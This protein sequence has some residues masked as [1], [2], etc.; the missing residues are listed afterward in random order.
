[1]LPI[2]IKQ[3]D[4]SSLSIEWNDDTKSE[5]SLIKLR[6]ACPCAICASELESFSH[7]YKVYRGNEVEIADI[8]MVG[9]HAISI[10][11]KDGHRTGMYEFQYLKDLV[12]KE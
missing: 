11:W 12:E 6:K 9:N 3:T 4:N 10:A 5:I 1:M 2:K 7:S 8:S